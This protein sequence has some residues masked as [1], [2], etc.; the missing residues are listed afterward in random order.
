MLLVS[1]PEQDEREEIDVVIEVSA[2]LLPNAM[3]EPPP[4]YGTCRKKT[5]RKQEGA[6]ASKKMS[7]EYQPKLLTR[8]KKRINFIFNWIVHKF[9]IY[10]DSS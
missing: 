4:S 9:Q 6:R 2:R 10:L 5:E 7:L 1:F 3:V 8:P